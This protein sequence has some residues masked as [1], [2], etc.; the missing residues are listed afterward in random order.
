MSAKDKD[1]I[2]KFGRGIPDDQIDDII[3]R[4]TQLQSESQSKNLE[5]VTSPDELRALAAE[6]EI[7]PSFVEAAIAE[8]RARLDEAAESA[9][10]RANRWQR[11]RRRFFSLLMS[12]W[13]AGVCVLAMMVLFWRSWF[14]EEDGIPKSQPRPSQVIIV[15]SEEDT[16]PKENEP[17]DTLQERK[18]DEPIVLPPIDMILKDLDAAVSI[19]SGVNVDAFVKRDAAPPPPPAPPPTTTLKRRQG[20]PSVSL[21]GEWRLHAYRVPMNGR[22]MD[23]LVTKTALADRERWEFRKDGHFSHRMSQLF[24]TSGRY[25]IE[26]AVEGWLF[27]E[28]D[29]KAFVLHATE[30][31]TT[32]SAT[33]RPHEYFYGIS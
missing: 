4:A 22:T 2:Q 11:L 33:P 28:G 14:G 18:L 10:Q 13:F 7:D 21:A 23:V 24:G 9:R 16:K 26:P 1:E 20:K 6:L 15:Q 12:R 27:S 8:R 17:T 3:L 25:R 29:A 19:D 30:V 5:S 31:M 32:L